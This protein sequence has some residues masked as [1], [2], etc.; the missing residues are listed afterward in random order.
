MCQRT[1]APSTPLVPESQTES[2]VI[3]QAPV[4][5]STPLASQL[6]IKSPAGAQAAPVQLSPALSPSYPSATVPP[7]T[8][9]ATTANG[10]Q[11]NPARGAETGSRGIRERRQSGSRQ[12]G[13]SSSA[14][15]FTGPFHGNPTDSLERTLRM[16]EP[17]DR[18]PSSHNVLPGPARAVP[19]GC[20]PS[21]ARA[22]ELPSPYC[23]SSQRLGAN[24]CGRGGCVGGGCR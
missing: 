7:L 19:S 11:Q 21:T 24:A 9:E 22:R 8:Y 18:R 15:A 3:F 14:S 5:L 20:A 16:S 10:G 12:K 17:L 1:F 2:P 6:H 4:P 23:A 13:C